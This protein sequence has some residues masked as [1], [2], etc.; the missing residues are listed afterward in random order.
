MNSPTDPKNQGLGCFLDR[1]RV[2]G[3]DCMAYVPP[4]EKPESV[5]YIGK[6]WA[7]CHLLINVHRTGKHI[8]I[9]TIT[10]NELLSKVRSYFADKQRN[11][12]TGPGKPL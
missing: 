6:E 7:K 8:S 5:D 4:I 2:C 9:L 1:S 3:P 11:D 12:Q 10:A